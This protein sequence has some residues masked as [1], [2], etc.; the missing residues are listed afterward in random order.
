MLDADGRPST[1]HSMNPVPIVV[2]AA[3]AGLRD[4]GVLADVAPTV[5]ELLG[6]PQPEAMTGQSLLQ[7]A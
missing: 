2:T 7:A 1:A 4:G 3:V 6:Q 5:L